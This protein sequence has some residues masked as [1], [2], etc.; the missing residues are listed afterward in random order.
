MQENRTVESGLKRGEARRMS[1]CDLWI[2]SALHLRAPS[3]Q[4]IAL[5]GRKRNEQLAALF[6]WSNEPASGLDN[7]LRNAKGRPGA[8]IGGGTEEP[9][10]KRNT[11]K[12]SN[13]QRRSSILSSGSGSRGA[14]RESL[15]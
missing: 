15:R 1:F 11:R 2:G 8:G 10:K 9:R 5:Y 4:S 3:T 13:G 12:R 6:T 14:A 7:V